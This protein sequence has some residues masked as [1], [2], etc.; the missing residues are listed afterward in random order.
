MISQ[1]FSC[2]QLR[3]Y[4]ELSYLPCVKCT[5]KNTKIDVLSVLDSKSV[6]QSY[7]Q[8]QRDSIF[9]DN[10]E[11]R[12]IYGIDGDIGDLMIK[13]VNHTYIISKNYQTKELQFKDIVGNEGTL[14]YIEKEKLKWELESVKDSI[15]GYLCQKAT[16][17]FG[18]R[19]WNAWFTT[20]IAI[21]DGPYKFWGLP[22]L[23][24]K[25][26]DEKNEYNWKLIA[27]KKIDSNNLQEINFMDYQGFDI[28]NTTKEKFNKLIK[29][30][31]KNPM[32]DIRDHIEDRDMEGEKSIREAE[33]RMLKYYKD[34]NNP[35]EIEIIKK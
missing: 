34:N 9:I 4:Y 12:K 20:E 3:F 5:E 29:Q 6:F 17:S 24:V 19:I 25:I 33:N 11:K 14:K 7:E 16:T 31:E 10:N 35:I 23:I 30:Y 15:N 2:Q 18:G 8:L 26:S 13:R 32:G 27:N 28:T 21:Q 22:G 1:C